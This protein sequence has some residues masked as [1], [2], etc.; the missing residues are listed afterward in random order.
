MDSNNVT[1]VERITSEQSIIDPDYA[2]PNEEQEAIHTNPETPLKDN[3]QRDKISGILTDHINTEINGLE[4]DIYVIDQRLNQTRLVLDRL[5]AA[6]LISYYDRS[7]TKSTSQSSSSGAQSGIHPAIKA[8]IGKSLPQSQKLQFVSTDDAVKKP[9]A[10]MS[11]SKE[12][13]SKSTHLLSASKHRVIVGNVSKYIPADSRQKNDQVSL[14]NNILI[15][16]LRSVTPI[17]EI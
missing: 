5:R 9:S 1:E 17:F 11:K 13:E 8:E 16:E 7:K 10:I 6:M 12:R 2:Q 3:S 15:S 14:E 4:N